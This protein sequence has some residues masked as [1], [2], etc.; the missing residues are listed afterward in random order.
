MGLFKLG[1][2]LAL[3]CIVVVSLV[4][5]FFIVSPRSVRQSQS[6]SASVKKS[7]DG[8][9]SSST[10]AN[11][12][13]DPPNNLN[14]IPVVI[15]EIIDINSVRVLLN[16]GMQVVD[17]IGIKIPTSTSQKR[18]ETCFEE[19]IEESIQRMAL[20]KKAFMIDDENYKNEKTPHK[21]IFLEDLTFLNMELVEKGIANAILTEN[22]LYR[23]EFAEAR[24]N[25][26]NGSIG[27]W[28][29]DCPIKKTAESKPVKSTPT[30]TVINP[31]SHLLPTATP[32]L[33]ATHTP[34]PTQQ[35]VQS[36]TTQSLSNGKPTSLNSEILFALI[37]NH[38]QS[39][40]K[41]PFEKD[42]RL[43]SLARE[44]GP[45]LYDEIFVTHNVHA[46][47]E[48]RNLPYWITENM[49]H[50]PTEE[51]VFNWWMGSTIHR[52]AIEGDY[53]YSCGECYGK[54]CAQLFTSFIAK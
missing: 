3:L 1:I 53:K 33:T 4:H 12:T 41:T 47:L 50:Y 44:R 34:A 29:D 17:L 21:Y 42:E 51:Q 40:G 30:P 35:I 19:T 20:G 36:A 11:L 8:V 54:S 45:E 25:A 48:R 6:A 15:I 18:Y 14:V 16:D 5:L 39:I 49:A 31:Y 9:L 24:L 27:V 46:G 32:K 52:R 10:S 13:L 2:F 28:H 26:E 37:N 7:A 22:Y 38:R 23:S 43:C